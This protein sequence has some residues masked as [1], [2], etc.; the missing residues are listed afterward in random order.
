MSFARCLIANKS[1]VV[2]AEITP[3]IEY[4]SWKLNEVGRAKFSLP[5]TDSKATEDILQFGNRVFFEFDNGLP[6][7]GGV[8]DPPRDWRGELIKC[9]AYSAEQIFGFR[10]TDKGRYFSGDTVGAIFQK[11]IREAND[12]SPMGIIVGDIWDGG[13]SHSPEYHYKSLLDIFQKSLTQRLSSAD[14]DVTATFGGGCLIFRGNLY[15]AKGGNKQGVGLVG[16]KNVTDMSLSEQGDIVNSWDVAGGGLTWGDSRLTGHAQDD[17]S[18]DKYGL[19]EKSSIQTGVVMQTTIDD[20]AK[21]LLIE[22][23]Q[24]FN[25]YSVDAVDEKPGLFAN[26]DLGDY[27]TLISHS[28]GFGGIDTLVRILGREYKPESDQCFLEV[29]EYI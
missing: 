9:I 15:Q 5:K 18:I 19:R 27:V 29:K 2:I 13:T 11:L 7:W 14:F 26:Y 23:K 1:N 10:I 17:A 28:H 20:N 21:N 6:N 22:T 4:I 25:E 3:D 24:P 12:I 16:G 8:I